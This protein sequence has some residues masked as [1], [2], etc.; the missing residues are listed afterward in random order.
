MEA[1]VDKRL[2]G[3]APDFAAALRLINE[4]A[5]PSGAVQG[6]GNGQPLDPS[7]AQPDDFRDF[8]AELARQLNVWKKD[9]LTRAGDAYERMGKCIGASGSTVLRAFI[10]FDCGECREAWDRLGG[11]PLETKADL[12][13]RL[14][15]C[16]AVGL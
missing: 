4:A 3:A 2:A 13:R 9:A 7:V 14:A 8:V 6:G 5:K 1:A 15:L 12:L 11:P 10:T 16:G